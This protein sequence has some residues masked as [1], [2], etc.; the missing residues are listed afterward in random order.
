MKETSRLKKK[1]FPIHLLWEE[2]KFKTLSVFKERTEGSN[3]TI[4]LAFI[5]VNFF[6]NSGS[7]QICQTSTS[8]GKSGADIET[9]LG[10]RDV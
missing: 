9:V 8:K 10:E 1:S 2:Q 5:S 7:S 3:L 4:C 6:I